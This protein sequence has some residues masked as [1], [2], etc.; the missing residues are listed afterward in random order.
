MLTQEHASNSKGCYIIRPPG[1]SPRPGERDAVIQRY[2]S[3]QGSATC[4]LIG[5][6]CI[7]ACVHIVRRYNTMSLRTCPVLVHYGIV[8]NPHR[9][10]SQRA[11]CASLRPGRCSS[12]DTSSTSA[13]TAGR[14]P[15]GVRSKLP[16]LITRILPYLLVGGHFLNGFLTKRCEKTGNY[17]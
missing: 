1:P 6:H 4:P 16:E 7:T 15:P 14:E 17:A 8:V 9:D 13:S 11:G 12:T 2:M 3:R 5:P 10:Q